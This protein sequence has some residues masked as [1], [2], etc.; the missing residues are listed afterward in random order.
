MLGHTE[1]GVTLNLYSH[2]TPT[3]QQQAADALDDLLGDTLA[4]N[5]AVNE[6]SGAS[7]QVTELPVTGS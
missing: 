1:V 3:L 7:A 2:V 6:A 5:L 4:V